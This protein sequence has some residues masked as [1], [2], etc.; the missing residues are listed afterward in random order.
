MKAAFKRYLPVYLKGMAMGAADVVPGVSGGTVAFVTG[1]Y[2]D[3]INALRAIRPATFSVLLKEGP[4]SA[5]R[6]INGNFLL[7][8]VAGIATS[9][10]TFAGIIS[11][12]LAT[13]PLLVWS[14]FFGLI[15]ASSVYMYRQ[16]EQRG[17]AEWVFLIIGLLFAWG[18][19]LVRPTEFPPYDWML[20]FAGAL[21]ICAMILPG[22]S[23]SFILLLIGAYPLFLHALKTPDLPMLGFFLAG[24]VTGLLLFSHVLGYL[25]AHF[26]ARTLALLTGFLFGSLSVIWPWKHVVQTRVNS[27][28]ETVPFI[29][30]NVMP[31]QYEALAGQQSQWEL[32]VLMMLAGCVL[33]W[34][35]EWV[36]GVVAR[37]STS[38]PKKSSDDRNSFTN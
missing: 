36:A 6:A 1:I 23:G 14:L 13:Y 10:F 22:I 31:L 2:D 28:G 24:C 18:V 30:E 3:F 5:W 12:C 35:I 21:A 26:R 27:K 9:L 25:L 33:V 11:Y 17:R 34:G 37:R 15:F 4:A 8:V 32:C 20:F 29:Q 16:L 38:D 7:A 19:S